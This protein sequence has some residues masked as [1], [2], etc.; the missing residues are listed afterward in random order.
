MPLIWIHFA[1]GSHKL[2]ISN[3]VIPLDRTHIRMVGGLVWLQ[4]HPP[5]KHALKRDR[6]TY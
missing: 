1:M 5:K 2:D 6:T 4:E 3:S